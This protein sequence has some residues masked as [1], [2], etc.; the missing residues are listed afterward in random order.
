MLSRRDVLAGGLAA[1]AS[2]F[3]SLADEVMAAGPQPRTAVN[4]D[5]PAGACDCAVHVYGDPQRFPLW[6]GRTY[7]PETATVE[8]L[9]QLLQA[10]RLDRVV[11]V[12]ATPYGT[13]NSCVVESI[14]TLGNRARGVAMIDEHTTEASMDEMHRNGVCGIR[15]NIGGLGV[16]DPAGARQRLAAGLSRVQKR[17]WHIQ[18]SAQPGTFEALRDQLVTL[19]VPLVIDHFG[20][21]SA[22]AGIN[23]AGFATVLSLV[24][25]G[26]YIKISNADTISTLADLSDVT[27]LAK[28]IVAANP[29]RVLWGT[30]WPHPSAG[31]VPGRTST[32]LARHR[33]IDDGRMLNM[34]PVWVPDAKVRRSILVDN[35]AR[36]YGF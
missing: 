16:S 20:G 30:A 35:P 27:P 4:F 34:L 29:E 5:V 3:L 18:L 6:S 24:K 8:E 28:A 14:R 2:P 36:L 1:A 25:A 7:T 12:Q 32:D 26:A 9:R 19:P 10:L 15:L 17:K 11:I 23:Q 33:Q 22:S 21:A 31:S 13:D